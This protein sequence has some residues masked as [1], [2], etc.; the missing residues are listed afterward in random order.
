MQKITITIVIENAS[1][2]AVDKALNLSSTLAQA[3]AVPQSPLKHTKSEVIKH[4]TDKQIN[5]VNDIA[6]KIK[7]KGLPLNVDFSKINEWSQEEA[8]KVIGQL[9]Q[10]LKEGK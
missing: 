3:A 4:I 10:L 5:F 1:Q 7:R 2:E 9:K 6:N 8:V